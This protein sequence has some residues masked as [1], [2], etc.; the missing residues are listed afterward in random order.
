MKQFVAI[1]AVVAFMASCGNPSHSNVEST[2]DS[3][4]VVAD[5]TS[6]DTAAVAVD[7]TSAN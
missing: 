1:L 2:T 7:T 6:V 3:T 4:A 5:S